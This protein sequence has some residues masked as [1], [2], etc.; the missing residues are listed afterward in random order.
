MLVMSDASGPGVTTLS[1]VYF[2]GYPLVESGLYVIASTWAAPEMS[3]PGCVWTHSVLISFADLARMD[4]PSVL[5]EIMKQP[6]A[7]A[8]ADYATVVEVEVGPGTRP[9]LTKST[10]EFA[11]ILAKALYEYPDKQVWARPSSH[12]AH[13]DVVLRLWDQ[14]WPKLRRNFKFCTLTTTDR[15]IH[16]LQFDLQLTPSRGSNVRLRFA[17]PGVDI[18]AVDASDAVWVEALI[19]DLDEPRTRPL[20]QFLRQAGT[21]LLGG[22][23]AMRPMATLHAL[24]NFGNTTF[25]SRAVSKATILVVEDPQL[26][27]SRTARAAVVRAAL[28][29]GLF[30]PISEEVLDFVLA[31]FHLLGDSER[32]EIASLLSRVVWQTD[33][34]AFIVATY[35]GSQEVQAALR[36]GVLSLDKEAVLEA[37]PK[38]ADLAEPLLHLLPSLA[39]D[40]RFWASTQSWPT[41]VASLDVDV[42]SPAA[43]RAIVTGLHDLGAINSALHVIGTQPVLSCLE[44][45]LRRKI[46]IGGIQ[47]W[48]RQACND[49]SGVAQFLA[50]NRQSADLLIRL[51]ASLAPDAIPNDYGEDPWY[52]ALF[53]LRSSSGPLPVELCAYGFR[54]SLSWRS[55]SVQPLLQLTFEPLHEAAVRQA[56]PSESWNLLEPAL[57][58][59]PSSESWDN[60]LRLR[61][62]A[63]KKCVDLPVHPAG[64]VL[65]VESEGLLRDL[66]DAVW[67]LWN[68]PRYLKS[69]MAWL[70]DEPDQSFARSRRL[71]RSFVKERAKFWR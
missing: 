20:K 48:V 64:F 56:I 39:D 34:R 62:A 40:E 15:S 30:D 23:E 63:A 5:V 1:N 24:L 7:Q 42:E 52:V 9:P 16:E 38:F 49:V 3:R 65:L 27:Q 32:Q 67:P 36:E 37:L 17:T 33:P 18:E 13:V 10:R 66:M 35:E 44:E 69:V 11:S 14:Q 55:R 43:L 59:M 41:S 26:A 22:R 19:D 12:A 60:G 31:H 25:D 6:D 46:H 58:W 57:P 50:H 68:G 29:A 28:S 21:E 61:R 4:A 45:L 54:R 53:N 70:D 51:A 2:T 47:N 8:V 71:V